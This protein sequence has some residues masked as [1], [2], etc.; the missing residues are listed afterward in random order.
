V[1]P[2]RETRA[3]LTALTIHPRETYDDV[4]ARLADQLRQSDADAGAGRLV[5]LDAV[6]TDLELYRVA[7]RPGGPGV[8]LAPRDRVMAARIRDE[9]NALRAEESPHPAVKPLEGYD[10]PDYPAGTASWS[11]SITSG[12]RSSS[13]ASG[14]ERT[15]ATGSDC[16]RYRPGCRECP[17]LE[18]PAPR[19]QPATGD[20]S[21]GTLRAARRRSGPGRFRVQ[22]R[23]GAPRRGAASC[24]PAVGKNPAAPAPPRG[25]RAKMPGHP[26]GPAAPSDKNRKFYSRRPDSPT[27][28]RP[29]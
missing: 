9:V 11:N 7:C 22:A 21:S 25:G 19:R 17:A 28:A 23:S 15:S 29:G 16:P 24:R 5:D 12:G 20:R 4:V 14:P 3:R 6:C 26:P 8:V 18:P 10:P 2:A 1:K 27:I 13:A